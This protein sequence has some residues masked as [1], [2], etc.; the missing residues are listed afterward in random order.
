MGF[1]I[2][3]EELGGRESVVDRHFTY[4]RRVLRVQCANVCIG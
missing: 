2:Q 4:A 1:A 3:R